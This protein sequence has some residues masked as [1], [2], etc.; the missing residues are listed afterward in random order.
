MN[1][2]KLVFTSLILTVFSFFLLVA[3]AG[4]KSVYNGPVH[5][6][7]E[8]SNPYVEYNSE[9]EML[10]NMKVWG[11]EIRP[12]KR[13]PV[14]LIIVI[15]ESGSM[16]EKGKMTYARKAAKGLIDNLNSYDRVGVVAYSDYARLITPLQRL[17]NK[18]KLKKFKITNL[19]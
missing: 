9:R 14:N 1:N 2:K 15:D 7:P 11:D 3:H 5:V 6:T 13:P 18:S 16:N 17:T 8:I 4:A 12:V 10:V 19:F